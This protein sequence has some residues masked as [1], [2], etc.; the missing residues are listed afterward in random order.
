MLVKRVAVIVVA[1]LAAAPA[2]AHA[3]EIFGGL[4]IHDV[5]TPLTKSGVEGGADVQLGWRGGRIGATP[6]Q[7]YIFGA[8]NTAG[9]TSY[10]AVG[11]SARFGSS[12]YV[13]PGLG[14]AVHNGSARNF[15]DPTNGEIDFGSRVLFEPE[16]GI[17]ARINEHL[18]IE[19]SWVHMSHA[20]LFGRQNPG[21]DNI[22]VRLNLAL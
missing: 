9:E 11:L 1:L 18:S 14:I 2:P 16:L 21:I 8:L 15:E 20:Q 3:G 17:G 22:G 10:A 4:Y 5:D 7:P 13:R 6:L 19:A 12:V